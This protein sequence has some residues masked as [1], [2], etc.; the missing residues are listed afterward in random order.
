MDVLTQE[1]IHLPIKVRPHVK[2]GVYNTNSPKKGVRQNFKTLLHIA[3]EL[4]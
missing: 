1:I 4:D 2:N 3:L